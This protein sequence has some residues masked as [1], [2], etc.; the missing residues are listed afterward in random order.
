MVYSVTISQHSNALSLRVKESLLSVA[1]AERASDII[2]LLEWFEQNPLE[3]EINA[4]AL[5]AC[6][7]KSITLDK[8]AQFLLESLH[9]ALLQDLFNS[10]PDSSE[11]SDNVEP[12]PNKAF[13]RFLT[14]AGTTVAI[15]EGF[16]GVASILG[17]FPAIPPIA[18]FMA[19]IA[20]AAVAV[21]VFCGFDLV[22]IS[23]NLGVDRGKSYQLIDVLLEQVEQ[24]N[25]LREAVCI[26]CTLGN[27]EEQ[28]EL[29]QISNMLVK[30]YAALDSARSKYKAD[31]NATS[32]IVAKSV[33][34]AVA[35]IVFFA[36]GFFSGQSVALAAASLFTTSATAL[37][38]P[39]VV[40]S[41][42]VGVAA[43]SIF[44]FVQRPGLESL[45]SRWLGMDEEKINALIDD[46]VVNKQRRGLEQLVSQ[47]SQVGEFR[48]MGGGLTL[49]NRAP[50]Q[51]SQ[52]MM[53]SENHAPLVNSVPTQETQPIL[54][55]SN[56]SP[57]GRITFFRRS[58]SE[59]AL[60]RVGLAQFQALAQA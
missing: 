3:N 22:T 59:N 35:G 1:E 46:H 28:E 38:W 36:G 9:A 10:I 34:S 13:F 25:K 49:F 11:L 6:L 40:A 8:K 58:L 33:T 60:D 23:Q 27:V 17:L 52:P 55:S 21:I 29:L 51:E 20:F 54:P 30:R 12:Q 32:L 19:G 37:C 18:I 48:R 56:A 5:V 42:L 24:I 44:L 31:L 14:I 50:S 7:S 45:V 2:A 16:E 41:L 26:R 15:C 47:V 43:C 39:V 57:I 4:L 53:T